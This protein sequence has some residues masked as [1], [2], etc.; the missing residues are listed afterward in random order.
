MKRYIE[1]LVELRQKYNLFSIERAAADTEVSVQ[2]VR[3][4]ERGRSM[5]AKLIRYYVQTL[6]LELR[7]NDSYQADRLGVS[8]H[9]IKLDLDALVEGFFGKEN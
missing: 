4:F 8:K 1:Y 7:Y 9:H 2:T 6:Y 3:N 5:N